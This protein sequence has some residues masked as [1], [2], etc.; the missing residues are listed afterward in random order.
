MYILICTYIFHMDMCGLG[1]VYLSSIEI[2]VVWNRKSPP[3][4][5]A[6]FHIYYPLWIWG[7]YDIQYPPGS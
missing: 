6:I 4:I 3:W 5:Y 7:S 2:C 1:Y